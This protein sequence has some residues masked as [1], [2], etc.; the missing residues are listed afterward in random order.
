[1]T[2]DR[3]KELER[4]AVDMATEETQD[5]KEY[6]KLQDAEDAARDDELV[7]KR[8]L[9]DLLTRVFN[10]Q[11]PNL[12]SE[13]ACQRLRGIDLA[14]WRKYRGEGITPHSLLHLSRFGLLPS[15]SV[16]AR[17]ARCLT[18]P[19][20][21]QADGRSE[22]TQGA[23]VVGECHIRRVLPARLLSYSAQRYRLVTR[24]RGRTWT[25]T[26]S[27]EAVARD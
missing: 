22:G 7:A 16:L 24:K 13:E 23:R 12:S 20:R 5:K 19:E 3:V 10:G 25:Y 9:R 1:M 18:D 11:H 4:T 2:P 14:P 8:L 27:S 21:L 26:T 6:K 15:T 17:D